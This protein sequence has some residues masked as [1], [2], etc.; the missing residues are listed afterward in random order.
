MKWVVRY[1]PYNK[2]F[3][4]KD[5]LVDTPQFARKFTAEKLAKAFIRSFDTDRSQLVAEPL[6]NVHTELFDGII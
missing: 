4:S 3:C 2:Y 5:R 1:R 6:E